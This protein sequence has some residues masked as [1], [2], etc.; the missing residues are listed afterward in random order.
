MV[1]T[2]ATRRRKTAVPMYELIQF[3]WVKQN[4][5]LVTEASDLQQK[6]TPQAFDVHSPKTGAVYRFMFSMETTDREGEVTAW[7]YVP[8]DKTCPVKLVVVL[9]D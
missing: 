1:Q 2:T 3:T 7:N 4:A 5:T 9:N 6:R 8:D